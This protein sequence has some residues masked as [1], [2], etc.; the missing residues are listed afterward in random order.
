MKPKKSW[1][2]K[3]A[4]DK[5]LPKVARVTGKMSRRWGEAFQKATFV[6]GHQKSLFTKLR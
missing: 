2:E 3:L 1:R 6:A 5:A 4:D